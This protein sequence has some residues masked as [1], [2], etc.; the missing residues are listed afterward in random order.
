MIRIVHRIVVDAAGQTV[1]KE[2]C[3][4]EL[5][6]PKNP[7]DKSPFAWEHCNRFATIHA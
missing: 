1:I 5:S 4:C 6:F 2:E 3:L 7:L